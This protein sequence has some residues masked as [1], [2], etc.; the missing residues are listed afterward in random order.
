MDRASGLKGPILSEPF[1]K[2]KGR[3][4]RLSKSVIRTL[5]K[6]PLINFRGQ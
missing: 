5:N 6:V 3:L 1:V 2:G 4:D